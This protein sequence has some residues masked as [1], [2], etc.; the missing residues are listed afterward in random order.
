MSACERAARRDVG[1]EVIELHGHGP[2]PHGVTILD[3]VQSEIEGLRRPAPTPEEHLDA[4][5]HPGNEL[6]TI[7][8]GEERRSARVRE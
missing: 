6:R 7:L 5:R 1:D 2:H 4:I 3:H 8:R